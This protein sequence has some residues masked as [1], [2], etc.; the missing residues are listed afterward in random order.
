MIVHYLPN[1]ENTKTSKFFDTIHM[2]LENQKTS[3]PFVVDGASIKGRNGWVVGGP[4]EYLI[5]WFEKDWPNMFGA[6]SMDDVILNP[7]FHYYYFGIKIVSMEG[8]T[9][10]RI[11]R[12]RPAAYAD[13]FA[14][15]KFVLDKLEIPKVPEGYWKNHVYYKFS[16]TEKRELI[17]KII[18]YLKS[19]YNLIV[20]VDEIKQILF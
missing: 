14:M 3:F 10:R 4:K 15:R 5:E 16:D 8:D 20:T 11:Q 9:K 19:R 2:Y 1:S 17:K 12:S 13:L 18:Y 7:K 6:P